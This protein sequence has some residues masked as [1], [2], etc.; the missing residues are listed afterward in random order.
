MT[1][2]FCLV[3]ILLMPL[4]A[5]GLALIHQGLGRSRSAAHAMLATLCALSI[6]AILFV[7]I[8]SS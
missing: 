3:C 1:P 7:L 2:D 5:T 6:A 8:G 4:A